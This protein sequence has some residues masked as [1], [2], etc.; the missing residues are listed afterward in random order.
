VGGGPG[1]DPPELGTDR[2]DPVLWDALR[3]LD[4]RTRAAVELNVLDG[5][6]HREIAATF[7]VPE[8][9]VARWIFRG[10]A[11]LRTE[12]GLE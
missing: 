2:S 9:T 1:G 10:R 8:G 12:L 6:T 7:A 4:G 5:Y 3:G 11:A